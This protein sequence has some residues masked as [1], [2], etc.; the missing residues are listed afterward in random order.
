MNLNRIY[1]LQEKLHTGTHQFS[2]K[3]NFGTVLVVVLSKYRYLC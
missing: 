3:E 2:M 1:C